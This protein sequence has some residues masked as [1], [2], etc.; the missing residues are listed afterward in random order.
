MSV[1]WRNKKVNCFIQTDRQID[2]QTNKQIDRQT[3][4]VDLE[5]RRNEGCPQ[6]APLPTS[7]A[8]WVKF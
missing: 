3:E 1:K 4:F 6:I 5:T 7:G 2:R 8:F